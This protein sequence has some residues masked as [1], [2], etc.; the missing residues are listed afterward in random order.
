MK[1]I[2][3]QLG[4]LL[5][6]HS[7]L[8][9]VLFLFSILVFVVNQLT[10]ILQGMTWADLKGI[11]FA[12]RKRTLLA[13]TAVG[14]IS[15][16][17][18]LLY[19]WVTVEILE[20]KG[21]SRLDRKKL[22]FSAWATNTLNNLAGFGGVLGATLRGKFY[23]GEVET[24]KVVSSV[25]KVAVFMLSGLSLLC[26]GTLIDV[27][28]I[29]PDNPFRSYSIW[30]LAGSFVTPGLSIFI[31]LNRNKLFQD[32][33]LM[34][35]LKLMLASLGQWSGALMMFLTVGKLLQV[36]VSLSTIYPL[37]IAANF[38]GMISM[39]PGG[40]GTFDVL[41]IMGLGNLGIS[42]E[43]AL[44]WLLFYRIFYYIVP[45]FT[46]I[47]SLIHLTGAKMNDFFDNI[48]KLVIQRT[49][50]LILVGMVYFAGIM[51]VLLATIPNLSNLSWIIEKLLPFS[52][53]FLDQ[54]LNMLVGFMLLGLARGVSNRVKKAY[55]PTLM[56]LLFCIV[57]TISRTFSWKL[58]IFYA[59]LCGC[60]YLARHE[61]YRKQL[62]FTWESLV[63]DTFLYGSL[64]ILY[65]VV[66]YYS[67]DRTN[68]GDLPSKFLL[69]PSEDVWLAGFA[70]VI[71]AAATI[72]MLYDYLSSSERPGVF[73]DEKQVKAMLTQYP[74]TD[75]SHLAHL[76]DKRHFY[77]QENGADK[78]MFTFEVQ[79]S[80]LFVL[81]DP[82]G[83]E[84]LYTKASLAFGDEADVLG[85]QP[86]FYGV[87][88]SYALLLHDI[89][90]EF[91]KLGEYGSIDL[92]Q[93]GEMMVTQEE[94]HNQL[95][96]SGYRFE[97]QEP[98]YSD[99]LIQELTAL[100]DKWSQHQ[101]ERYFSVG[102]F[103]P[104]YIQQGDLG[105]VF[106][107][108]DNIVGFITVK[109]GKKESEVGYDLIRMAMDIP[110][111][112]KG[113]MVTSLAE[114]CRKRG[115]DV[116]TIGLAPL[117]NVGESRSAFFK[118]RVINIFYKYSNP[119]YAFKDNHLFKEEFATNWHPRYLSYKKNN[120]LL[121]LMMQL[122]LVIVGRKSKRTRPIES[123]YLT[124]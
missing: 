120:N 60:L 38:I 16:T 18:M 49:A 40:M 70:G 52:F 100:S 108:E 34:R 44:A 97:Y 66:G 77:Y 32:F 105:L 93:Q 15:V 9:K 53:N 33:P 11:L 78:V 80:K 14:L 24:K 113:F 110:D 104:Y 71:L 26:L 89:G 59:F 91:I 46:G 2:I 94:Q 27:T 83:D 90:Y 79:G 1:K 114:C 58:V 19:D 121:L 5:K 29:R 118:E 13:M 22:L 37:F 6:K 35:V 103:N 81:G 109:P 21:R 76:R 23:G 112:I 55:F 61:F 45:F 68:H 7:G 82:V 65:S 87:T 92:E 31:Y 111:A 41:M 69:F 88:D 86:V 115:V 20:E 106:N 43:F 123:F 116:V 95:I 36:D 25:S 67:S 73:Y 124:D 75:Y 4:S 107:Q 62:I 28:F 17:P 101:P 96:K 102:R 98:P 30:L 8:L 56:V 122:T 42:K 54:T 57:N 10:G 119:L 117:A 50:H 84:S 3:K 51:M 12:Q 47:Y 72:V 85:Y 39:V 74:G 99:A 48:P 63:F 64:F